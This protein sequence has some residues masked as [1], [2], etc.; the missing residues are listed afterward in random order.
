V[1]W[2][3]CYWQY[4]RAITRDGILEDVT[5]SLNYIESW[6]NGFGG[7]DLNGKIEDLATAEITRT[8]LW[9]W[10]K[11][12]AHMVD[13]KIV[14]VEYVQQIIDDIYTAKRRELGEAFD[15][16]QFRL[17]RE[18]LNS[19]VDVTK[20]EEWLP[21]MLYSHIVEYNN[22]HVNDSF[23]FGCAQKMIVGVVFHYF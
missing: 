20:F 23:W 17:A 8:Q 2:L 18:K 19:L 22:R 10:I 3:K 14:T 21:N 7:C 9:Q 6:L 1:N 13:G 11:H 12:G 4:L 16:R 5:V 15:Q